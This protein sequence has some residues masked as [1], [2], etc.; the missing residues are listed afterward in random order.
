M[1]FGIW[2]SVRDLRSQFGWFDRT[3]LSLRNDLHLQC[4]P[5]A[6][7][8]HG[9]NITSSN[10]RTLNPRTLNRSTSDRF[11]FVERLCPRGQIRLELRGVW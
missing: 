7:H 3:Y 6:C 8:E 2:A 1:G 9:D 10:N 5:P 4:Y 11:G